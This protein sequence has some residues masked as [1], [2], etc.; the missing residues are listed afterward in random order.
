MN[1]DAKKFFFAFLFFAFTLIGLGYYHYN[2]ELQ[3]N[4]QNI[5]NALLRASESAQIII[6]DRYHDQIITTP[7]S[8]VEDA[9]IIHALTTLSHSQGTLYL[10]SL[11]LDPYGNVRFS[12]SSARDSKL[13]KGNHLTHFYDIYP[14]N[15]NIIKAFE[16]GK[17]VFDKGETPAQEG[18][19][20][21]IFVPHTTPSG[22]RYIIGADIEVGSIQKLSNAAA[23]KAISTSLLIFL[24]AI[25][26]LMLYR[27]MLYNATMILKEEVE[28]A[29][30]ELREV[31]EILENK[32]EEKTKELISQ[33]FQDALTELPN[34]HR[35]QYDM[36]RS[37]HAILI[38]LNLHNFKE[39]NDFFGTATGDDLL[40][41]TGR[42]LNRID[43][44]PYRLGGDEF[45][46]LLNKDYTQPQLEEFCMHLIHR[47][48][49]HPFLVADETI[50]L[51]ITVGV[52]PGPNTSLAHAD[53]AL[54]QAKE[55]GKSLAFYDGNAMVEEQY[56]ANIATAS[57]IHKALNLGRI[58]CYYQPIVSLQSEGIDKYETLVRMVDESGHIIP[59]VDFLKIAQKTRLYPK[60]T[61]VVVR[62]ACEAFEGRSEEFSINLSIRDILDPNTVHIIE[63]T[64]VKT[65]TA[66]R[67]VF[68]ILES[69]GIEN[70]DAVIAFMHR[71]KK[72]GARI[73]VDDF[74]TGYSSFE[75]ILKLDPDYIKIDGSLIRSINTDP[76]HAIIVQAIADFASKLG[77]K[78][79]AEF[80]ESEEIFDH[81]KM[82]NITY[83]Q[84][85][86]SGKPAPL[87]MI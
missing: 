71:M 56:K 1:V 15:S 54:H 41:Q 87:P 80:V 66:H 61:E 67:V 35:L 26:F 37:P 57:A 14:H 49:D 62:Q 32:V 72:L 2:R 42:W 86:Y 59:P 84:G 58:I 43:L 83:S 4:N 19:F 40:R 38:I 36:Q 45:A 17:I 44:T 46:L 53:I 69:E 23:F 21:S 75:N 6:G 8:A 10:Y 12:A 64:I 63:E 76:K 16:S 3:S 78:T 18:K 11:V 74:G 31:N 55:I 65:D 30:D 24:G 81:L 47:L 39:I 68:E 28:W 82:I 70:F 13:T 27:N 60:I 29:T 77:A 79:I 33:S 51:N 22:H 73:A 85:Y 7:P 20:R 52:D 25:P 50:S 9:D 34:R 48:A 5:E